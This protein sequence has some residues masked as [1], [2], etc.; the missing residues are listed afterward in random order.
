MRLGWGR[1]GAL[2]TAN[3]AGP[4]RGC[5]GWQHSGSSQ[6]GESLAQ[7]ACAGPCCARARRPQPS[8]PLGPLRPPSRGS[9]PSS[10]PLLPHGQ[11]SR[12]GL[13]AG[14][15]ARDERLRWVRSA[16]PGGPAGGRL[17]LP[18][19]RTPGV[20]GKRR[21]RERSPPPGR[22]ACWAL[23][24]AS[25]DSTQA[26]SASARDT[27]PLSL[28]A[29]SSPPSPFVAWAPAAALSLPLQA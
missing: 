26:T 22:P 29:A 20:G 7:A 21:L 11:G 8:Q 24:P 2:L 25:W 17:G 18:C 16:R 3:L 15:G 5:G 1:D 9:R 14:A 12:P 6:P 23:V 10:A 28:P 19:R 13:G 4:G 27:P